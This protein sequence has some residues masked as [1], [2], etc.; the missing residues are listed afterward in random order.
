MKKLT[1]LL[2][3][4]IS[5]N[6]LGQ[7]IAKNQIKFSPIR[8]IESVNPGL[9]ISYERRFQ[10]ISFQLSGTYLKN[11]LNTASYEDFEGQRISFELKYFTGPIKK[12]KPYF[13]IEYVYYQSF[14][15]DSTS[16]YIHD[17]EESEYSLY[18]ETYTELHNINKLTNSI[19]FK[20]GFQVYIT[21]ITVIDVGFGVGIKVKNTIHSGRSNPADEM[22]HP[23]HPNVHYYAKQESNNEVFLNIPINF[24]I[25]FRF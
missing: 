5:F 4:I 12:L 13:A 11:F 23:R 14:I 22:Y 3:I 16:F 6:S 1:L 20:V 17:E 24:K 18:R 21:K 8:L 9:E 2:F 10:N 19:N 15:K 25:G 7:E